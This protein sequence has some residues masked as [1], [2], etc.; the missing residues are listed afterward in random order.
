[1]TRE[2]SLFRVEQL[3]KAIN[4]LEAEPKNVLFVGN[5]DG[6]ATAAMSLGC[7]F[8]RVK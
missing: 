5:T 6:D 1:M 7:Q 3:T 4:L 2:D 8:M